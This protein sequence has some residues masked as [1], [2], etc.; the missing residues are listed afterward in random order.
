MAC[1]RDPR[2]KESKK[3][4]YLPCIPCKKFETLTNICIEPIDL[5]LS[6]EQTGFDAEKST[7][8]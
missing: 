3:Q 4:I 2:D 5:L 7:V 6:G 8:N 1:A